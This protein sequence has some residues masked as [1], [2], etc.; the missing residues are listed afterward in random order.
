MGDYIYILAGRVAKGSLV[1]RGYVSS[2]GAV[3]E[4]ESDKE[5]RG[6]NIPDVYT[7]LISLWG[8]NSSQRLG[9]NWVRL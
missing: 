5:E 4:A 1:R 6:T 3:S 8:H 9:S 7:A 2:W